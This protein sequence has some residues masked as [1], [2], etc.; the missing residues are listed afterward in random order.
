MM[1]ATGYRRM[2]TK[3]FTL[4]EIIVVLFI[5]GFLAGGVAMVTGRA[6]EKAAVI[7]TLSEM[8]NI[9]KAVRQ[10]YADLGLIPEDAANPEY[11]SRYLCLVIPE[12]A[13][14][15]EYASRYL[16]LVNDGPGNPEYNEMRSFV[17]SDS[18]MSWNKFTKRGWR[19][20]YMEPD[21]R[22]HDIADDQWYPVLADSWGNFYRI[23][24]NPSQDRASA[25]I[26]SLGANGIDDGGT[27]FPVPADIGDDIVMFI[28]GGG[29]T[30]SPL[31]GGV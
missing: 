14:N 26:V 11:A 15:P 25:R 8:H 13:A 29:E 9:K 1:T 4:A 21:K 30:R 23:L 27:A 16:C 18:L 12:D 28:F 7:T 17:G 6:R 10:F 31:D 5:I 19:G 2:N 22:Y 20:P 3:G 24:M